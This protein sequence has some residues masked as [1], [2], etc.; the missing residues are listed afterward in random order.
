[1]RERE[2]EKECF[3]FRREQD[4]HPA[5]IRFIVLAV[6]QTAPRQSIHQSYNTVVLEI[7]TFG[8][9]ARAD[10]LRW[11][12]DDLS[13]ETLLRDQI[14][15]QDLVLGYDDE[16]VGHLADRMAATE[17]G[18]V[19]IVNRKSGTRRPVKWPRGA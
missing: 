1:V 2:P 9:L 5:T 8:E 17:I 15:G 19:P 10:A 11:L 13:P 6:Y 12:R 18:R 14:A 16:L 7:E 3:G 4:H